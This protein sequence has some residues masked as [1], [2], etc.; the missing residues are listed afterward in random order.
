MDSVNGYQPFATNQQVCAH[1]SLTGEDAGSRTRGKPKVGFVPH[2]QRVGA[3]VLL[4]A[5]GQIGSDAIA[6]GP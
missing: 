2:Y 1:A 3:G 4:A 6:R 5:W